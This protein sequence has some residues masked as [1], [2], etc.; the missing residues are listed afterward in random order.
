MDTTYLIDEVAV[1]AASLATDLTGAVTVGAFAVA[2]TDA[3]FTS[4]TEYAEAAMFDTAATPVALTRP[5]TWLTSFGSVDDPATATT[6]AR[7]GASQWAFSWQVPNAALAADVYYLGLRCKT[8]GTNDFSAMWKVSVTDR[9]VF[10][11]AT[12]DLAKATGSTAFAFTGFAS[13]TE[14]KWIGGTT[15]LPPIPDPRPRMNQPV[16]VTQAFEVE[17]GKGFHVTLSVTGVTA[18]V[19]PVEELVDEYNK[20]L[21]LFA[22]SLILYGEVAKITTAS[23]A[24]VGSEVK[25]VWGALAGADATIFPGF[26]W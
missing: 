16:P 14:G 12:A 21:N 26:S 1:K 11:A 6:N 13:A 7:N 24:T 17:A 10:A 15:A 20:P 2:I 4:C 9:P 23:V 22:R 19:V 5:T 18:T 8:T 25:Q 3:G